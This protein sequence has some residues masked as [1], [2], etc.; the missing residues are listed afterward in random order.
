MLTRLPSGQAG[1]DQ[2]RDLVDAAA[3]LADDAACATCIT[4]GLVAED[5]VGELELALALDIDLLGAVDH[6][7]GD[8]LV[9]EQRLERAEAEHVVDEEADD[10]A[11]LGWLS[12]IFSSTRIS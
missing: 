6:D 9:G 8:G 5:G 10:L 2:R 11:L 4:C 3:D 1:V 12:W 7:V